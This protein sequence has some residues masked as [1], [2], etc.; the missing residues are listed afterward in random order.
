[1]LRYIILFHDWLEDSYKA[2]RKYKAGENKEEE[3]FQINHRLGLVYR[4]QRRRQ[5]VI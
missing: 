2:N 4:H 3:Y 5:A 1:M